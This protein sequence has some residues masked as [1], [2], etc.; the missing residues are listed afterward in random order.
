MTCAWILD[1]IPEPWF[2]NHSVTALKAQCFLCSKWH[3]GYITCLLCIHPCSSTIWLCSMAQRHN[4]VLYGL[5]Y[6]LHL[7]PQASS[8]YSAAHCLPRTQKGS[9]VSLLFVCFIQHWCNPFYLE[10]GFLSAI[11]WL[12]WELQEGGDGWSTC[13]PGEVLRIF[14]WHQR[15]PPIPLLWP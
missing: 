11:D 15:S 7:C 8:N 4:S 2:S 12:W 10:P 14:P 13:C 1:A 3:C 9:P 6:H 5:E